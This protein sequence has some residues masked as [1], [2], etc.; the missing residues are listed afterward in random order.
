MFARID[1]AVAM[2]MIQSWRWKFDVG[3]WRPSQAI[4]LADTDGNPDTKAE[5]WTALLPMPAYPDYTSGHANATAPFA[6]VVR[7][8]LGDDAALDAARS[9]PR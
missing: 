8:T 9:G 1:A 2:S 5:G 7:Q 3:F 4:P 6:E